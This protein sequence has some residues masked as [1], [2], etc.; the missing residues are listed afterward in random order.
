[1]IGR[2]RFSR[3]GPVAASVL[4]GFLGAGV[5]DVVAT[6]VRVPGPVGAPALFLLSFGLYGAAGLLAACVVGLLAAGVLGAIPGGAAAL[7]EDSRVDRRAAAGILSAAL[8]VALIGLLVAIGQKLL[9]RPMQSDKL[10]MIASGG[11]VLLAALPAAAVA[12]AVYRP[13]ERGV[14]PR[15]PRLQRLG[16]AG[17][18]LLAGAIAGG[19]ATVAA[20]SRADWRVLD[21]TPFAA[22]GLIFVAGLGHGLFWYR[23]ALGKRLA[24]RIPSVWVSHALVA[25]IFVAFVAASRLRD[26]SPAFAAAEHGSL[27]LRLAL[28]VARAA[29]DGDGDGFSARFGGGDC[30]DHRADVYPGAEDIPGNGI[31]ENCEGG[32]AVASAADE[33]VT[34]ATDTPDEAPAKIAGA[35]VGDKASAPGA[36]KGN[37][38]IITIDALR[39]DRLGVAGYGRPGGKSLTPN[40][41]ALA[42]RGAYFRRVWSQAPN[43]PRSFPAILTSQPPSGV[44]WDK[45]KVN[46]PNLLPENHTFFEDLRAAGLAPTGVFSHFYFTDDRGI[47]KS[48]KDWSNDGAGT[49]AESNKDSASPRIVPR[50]I[51]HLKKAAA[52]HDRFVIWTHL[53]EPH[54]SYM[55][56]KEF[57]T[58]GATGVPGLMEKYDYEIA[59]V[60]LWVGKLLKALDTLGLARSTAVVVMADHG[61]AW[62]EHKAMFHGTDLF[63]EQLRIPMIIAVPGRAPVVNDDPVAAVDLAPTLLELVGAPVPKSFR[64]RSLMPALA[65]AK[66]AP[67]PI[68]AELMPAT[69][70]PHHAV[71]L[72][73]GDK[74][75]IHRVS[76][77]RFELYDLGADPGEKHDLADDPGAHPLF[78]KMRR[79]LL[80]FEERRR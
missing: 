53:F 12:I 39:A 4:A 30:D 33:D 66:L 10:A 60:D 57:P 55:P 1:M 41:D 79:T 38:L 31:D 50:V 27:G 16:T 6:M 78:E 72:L 2:L 37:I 32:D 71:M 28:R 11:L 25:A 46:Y 48:F 54:S 75:L 80:A 51:A 26:Q 56:H 15:L 43:T 52:A 67:R 70:W 44:K 59:F 24:Q 5:A 20:F 63:D 49:I 13:L 29:T 19:L 36:F 3:L 35:P 68:Y 77:R 23:S 61:E 74:K 21:L 69:A 47:S 18:L 65:G 14:V 42:R 8:G 58:S 73:D 45:P 17:S 76:E 64:G 62:S 7:V 34:A 22:L 9:V 40:L